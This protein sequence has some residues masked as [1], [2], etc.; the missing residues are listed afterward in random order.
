M[1]LS[2]LHKLTFIDLFAGCGGVS[3]GLLRAGWKG[4]F[5]IEKSGMAFETLKHNLIDKIN[6]YDWPPWLPQAEH[7]INDVLRICREELEELNGKVSLVAGGPPCQ[8]FSLAGRRNEH[9][10]RNQ[11]V[12]TY[13]EFINIVRPHLV[14]FENVKG[15]AAGFKQD[16]SSAKAYSKFV[17]QKL[18]ELGYDVRAETMN[19]GDFGIPQRRKRFILLG[20]RNGSATHSITRKAQYSERNS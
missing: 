1:S 6:H 8:G 19:F 12:N 17:L 13:V 2:S 20:D 16:N 9:D 5:A 14:F 11:L 3:L 15:F 10:K 18:L 7:D 4:L